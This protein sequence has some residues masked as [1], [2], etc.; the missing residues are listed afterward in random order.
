M[1]SNLT[2]QKLKQKLN[3]TAEKLTIA[4]TEKAMLLK[5]IEEA[6]NRLKELGYESIELAE[7]A[8]SNIQQSI[9][10]KTEELDQLAKEAETLMETFS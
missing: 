8:R 10:Q 2:L 5:N 7:E 1:S 4:K 6:E 9:V 3:E